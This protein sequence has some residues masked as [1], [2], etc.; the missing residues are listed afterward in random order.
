[1]QVGQVPVPLVEVEPVADEQLVRDGEADVAHRQLVDEPAVRPVEERRDGERRGPAELQRAADVVQRQPGVDDVLDDEDVAAVD[2]RGE[3]LEQPDLLVPAG[4]GPRVARELEE[5]EVMEDRCRARE[6]GD[7]D[8]AR[9]QRGDE[10]RL[11]V[12]VL[13]GDL[14][15]EL[16][17]ARSDLRGG[18]IDLTD[19]V[20]GC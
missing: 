13:G 18:E 5:V 11:A 2:R 17:D 8:Q 10:K 1:V 20:V 15:P 19:P 3:V 9:L 6:V 12:A 7:E 16:R 14:A 4:G